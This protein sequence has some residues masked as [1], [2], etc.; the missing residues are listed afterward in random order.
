MN[1][2][3][4]LPDDLLGCWWFEHEDD[5]SPGILVLDASGRAVQFCSASRRLRQNEMMRLWF[6]VDDPR[7]LRF[8]PAPDAEGWTRVVS[9]TPDG[10]MISTEEKSFP[11]RKAIDGDLPE[12]FHDDLQFAVERMIERERAA[13]QNHGEQEAAL[14]G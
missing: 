1:P 4:T 11:M 5:N 7:T 14:D 12:W 10:F 3:F 6:S 8:R 9:R 13:K 2:D